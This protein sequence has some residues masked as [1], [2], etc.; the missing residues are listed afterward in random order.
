[1]LDLALP[2]GPGGPVA[3][4]IALQLATT[5]LHAFRARAVLFATGGYGKVFKVT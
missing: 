4:V 1:M 5:E 2:D 3:G